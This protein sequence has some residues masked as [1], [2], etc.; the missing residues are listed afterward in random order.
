MTTILL[1]ERTRDQAPWRDLRA[2]T[3]IVTERQEVGQ[4]KTEEVHSR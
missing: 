1:P 4:E 3:R 2:I